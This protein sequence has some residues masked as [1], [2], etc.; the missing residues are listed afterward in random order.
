MRSTIHLLERSHKIE[1]SSLSLYHVCLPRWLPKRLTIWLVGGHHYRLVFFDSRRGP[2]YPK[3][4]LTL[5]SEADS[6]LFKW[7][8]RAANV[9]DLIPV[10]I[11]IPAHSCHC[12]GHFN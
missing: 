4:A 3:K 1:C 12:F 6:A 2:A 8:Q 9:N 5:P 10:V 11:L 7:P